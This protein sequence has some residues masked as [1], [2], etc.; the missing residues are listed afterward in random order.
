[1][2]VPVFFKRILR[3][4]LRCSRRGDRNVSRHPAR[5]GGWTGTLD[6]PEGLGPRTSRGDIAGGN[7]ETGASTGASPSSR[8]PKGPLALI[9]PKGP[10]LCVT[11]DFVMFG[12]TEFDAPTGEWPALHAPWL[13][14]PATTTAELRRPQPLWTGRGQSAKNR[15][16]L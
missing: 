2:L 14:H 8:R 11:G 13:R 9:L 1:T 7:T 3:N 16:Q 12:A 6:P 5:E 10:S 15:G 4:L